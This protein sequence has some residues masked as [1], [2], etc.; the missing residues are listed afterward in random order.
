MRHLFT[1]F[2]FKY[3]KLYLGF[4][5]VC[6]CTKSLPGR[7]APPACAYPDPSAGREFGHR[8]VAH[9]EIQPNFEAS[10]DPVFLLSIE[11]ASAGLLQNKGSEG[12]RVWNGSDLTNI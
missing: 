3:D 8:S 11:A 12:S 2:K 7:F 10:T 6:V 9:V 1:C 5:R 4:A